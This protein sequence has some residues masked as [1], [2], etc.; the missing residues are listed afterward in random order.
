MTSQSSAH[1]KTDSGGPAD[2]GLP[3]L[4]GWAFW[5]AGTHPRQYVYLILS[6]CPTK[7]TFG[8]FTVLEFS[9]SKPFQPPITW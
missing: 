5:G 7:I 4:H 6:T 8:F 3:G 2:A 9:F 1:I